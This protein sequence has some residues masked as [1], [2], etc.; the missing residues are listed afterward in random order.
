[1]PQNEFLRTSPTQ[2]F[3]VGAD[4][5]GPD[6]V[7]PDMI[8]PG[9]EAGCCYEPIGPDLPNK[10]IPYMTM[11]FAPMAFSPVTGY[12][13]GMACV[14][15]RWIRRPENAWFFSGTAV[16]AP[17]LQQHGLHVALDSRTNRIALR[18]SGSAQVLRVGCSSIRGTACIRRPRCSASGRGTPARRARR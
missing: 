18:R 11:R 7:D 8:P 3:P 10:F 16:R 9:F 12:F 17:G 6:C 14:Y 15:P 13:Y 1:M 2:P 5:I 4:R